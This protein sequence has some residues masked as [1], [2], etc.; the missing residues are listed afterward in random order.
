M[1][2]CKDYNKTDPF[3]DGVD[4]A[5]VLLTRVKILKSLLGGLQGTPN[6]ETPLSVSY[7]CNTSIGRNF[8]GNVG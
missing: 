1:R 5:D 2:L 8:F 6:I 7:G 4:R 3:E